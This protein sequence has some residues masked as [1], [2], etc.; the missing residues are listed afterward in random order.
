MHNISSLSN[1]HAHYNYHKKFSVLT[2]KNTK[3]KKENKDAQD[4]IPL[5]LIY[6]WN[7]V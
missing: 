6:Y 1:E 5:Y 2:E 3:K 4:L 7:F